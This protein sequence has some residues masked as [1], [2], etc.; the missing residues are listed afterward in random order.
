MSHAWIDRLIIRIYIL[1]KSH[2]HAYEHEQAL[3][4]RCCG[5]MR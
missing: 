5:A 3:M 2:E 4:H 1:D